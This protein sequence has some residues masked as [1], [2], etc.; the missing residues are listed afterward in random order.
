MQQKIIQIGITI[1]QA[2]KQDLDVGDVI[3][4]ERNV[5]K[6]TISAIRQTNIINQEVYG[7]AKSLLSRYAAAFEELAIK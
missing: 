3:N 1:P 2:L 4:I 6:I 5:H 7:I